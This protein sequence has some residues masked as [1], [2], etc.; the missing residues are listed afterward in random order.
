[1]LKLYC[2]KCGCVNGYINEKP[3]FC[4]KC[5]QG[6]NLGENVASQEI[7]G[8]VKNTTKKFIP[9]LDKLDVEIDGGRSNTHVMGSIA[10]TMD[11]DSIDTEYVRGGA[12]NL[13]GE[14]V[15]KEGAAIKP[16]NR[17]PN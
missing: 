1:M 13:T 3:N 12:E 15:L 17:K 14:D 6:F 2:Q 5:G 4:H 9:Q 11:K 10:G 16:K 7:A 8:E